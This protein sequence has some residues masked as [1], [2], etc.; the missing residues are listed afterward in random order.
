[1]YIFYLNRLGGC[2][3]VLFV[4]RDKQSDALFCF[5]EELDQIQ[6]AFNLKNCGSF[7]FMYYPFYQNYSIFY[8]ATNPSYQSVFINMLDL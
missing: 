6:I 5:V 3:I 4:K 8:L 2:F 7:H 1:M